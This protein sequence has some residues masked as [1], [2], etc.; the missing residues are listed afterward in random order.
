[1]A[2]QSGLGDQLV[3]AGTNVSNDI[4]SADIS[5]PHGTFDV[6]GIDVT[7]H[8]RILG[9]KDGRIAVSAFWNP[10]SG[11]VHDILSALPTTDTAVQYQKGVVRGGP[12]A[13]LVAKQIN[14]DAARGADGQLMFNAEA[15]G[16]GYPTEWGNQLTAGADLLGAAGAGAGVDFGA[17]TNFGLQAYLHVLLFTGTSATVTLQ[18]FTADTPASYTDIT[19]AGFA[20]ASAVGWQRIQTS[21]T[22]TVRRWVRYNVTGTFSALVIAVA[23]VKNELAGV[24]F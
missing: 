15:L 7:A 24:N 10:A 17:A 18:D 1:M 9:R 2:K 21:R 5:S 3:I 6:T 13:N 8:E 19:G 12:V 20:A 22:Q 14:Y 23:V 4:Q 11:R 16:Q